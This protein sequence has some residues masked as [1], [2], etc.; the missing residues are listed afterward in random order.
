LATHW[1]SESAITTTTYKPIIIHTAGTAFHFIQLKC[2][3]TEQNKKEH[4]YTTTAGAAITE[5]IVLS[6]MLPPGEA[7]ES[8]EGAVGRVGSVGYAPSSG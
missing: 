7:V 5:Q 4:N 8:E 2:K 6:S 1:I 3:N